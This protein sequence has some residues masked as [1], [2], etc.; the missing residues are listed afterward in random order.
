LYDNGALFALMSGSG[1]TLFGV[2]ENQEKAEKAE[3]NFN[4]YFTSICDLV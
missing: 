3:K 2:F 4:N 1:S